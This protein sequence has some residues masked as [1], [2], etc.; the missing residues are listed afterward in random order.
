VNPSQERRILDFRPLG[1][2]DVVVLGRYRYAEAHPALQLHSHGQMIEICYLESGQQSYSVGGKQFLLHGG[3]LF[4]T[5]PNE[6]HGSDKSPEGKGMLY[7]M[8]IQVP[9]GTERLLSLGPVA[10]R[11]VLDRLLRL[12]ARH[13][14][15]GERVG[16]ILR[17]VIGVFDRDQD[18]L[19]VVN[20]QNLL[21]RFL[22]DVLE[23]SHDSHRRVS[24][25]IRAVQQVI[26]ENLDQALPIARLARVAHMSASRLKA[27]FK[28]EV[29]VPPADYTMRQ[30]IDRGKQFLRQ[31]DLSVTEIALRLGFSSTQYFATA[32]KRYTGQ[33][34]SGYRQFEWQWG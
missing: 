29:G 31:G 6:R 8:L 30:R 21:L 4:V 33:T 34:P 1:F 7:W 2:H 16:R 14:P 5:F 9:R 23:A 24:P 18:P 32:F 28:A 12:P 22:L 15:G 27:R 26:A 17:R 10:T 11:Q 13:F 3:D 20:L 19:R 25:E